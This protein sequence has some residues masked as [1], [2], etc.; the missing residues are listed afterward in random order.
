[1]GAH[2]LALLVVLLPCVATERDWPAAVRIPV[3]E[4]LP[5]LLLLAIGQRVHRIHH[6]RLD[7]GPGVAALPRAKNVVD[8]RN[9]VSHALARARPRRQHVVLA[10]PR[11]RDGVSLVSVKAKGLTLAPSLR[12]LADAEDP[13]TLRM[14][15]PVPHEIVDEAPR[16]ERRVQLQRRIGPQQP[17]LELTLDVLPDALVLDRQKRLGVTPV[18]LDELVPKRENIQ[19]KPILRRPAELSPAARR[20]NGT[21]PIRLFEAGAPRWPG[22]TLSEA[23][24]APVL[25]KLEPASGRQPSAAG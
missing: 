22:A 18:V 12:P 2:L 15:A 5:Q 7:P 17:A 21:R 25:S 14:Q 19:S 11:R 13:R 9:D 16:R 6:D 3:A 1:M 10:R 20:R 4:E 23:D 24:A 8:D